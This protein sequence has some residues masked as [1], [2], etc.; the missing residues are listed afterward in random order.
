MERLVHN[1]LSRFLAPWLTSNE[2]GFKKRDGSTPQLIRLTQ[3]WADAI[4][5]GHYVAAVFFDLRKAF[6]RV[7]HRG[8]LVKLRAADISGAAYAWLE[9]FLAN[10]VQATVVDGSTSDFSPLHAGV[11]QGAILS[12]LFFSVY[13]NDI[14][15]A[16]STNFSLVTRLFTLWHHLP[17]S[18]ASVF[19]TRLTQ[20]AHGSANGS[21]PSTLQSRLSLCFAPGRCRP[22]T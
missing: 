16:D 12:P 2:S 14:P 17:A 5:R 21:S 9:S 15:L 20:F 19:R 4:N 18:W 8:L 6:D 22:L 13:M 1:K 10:R 3:T 7:W 11:P